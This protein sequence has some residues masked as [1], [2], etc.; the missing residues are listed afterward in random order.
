M[1]RSLLGTLS[2]IV[3]GTGPLA[4]QFVQHLPAGSLAT[5]AESAAESA[6]RNSE[7]APWKL[8][9]LALD[10]RFSVRDLG[11]HENVFAN[12]GETSA[13]NDF[14]GTVG[15]GLA[16]YLNLGSKSLASA[17]VTPEYSWWRDQDE[18][19]R[20][21]TSWGVGWFGFF[22]NLTA[23]ARFTVKD[24]E[25]PLSDEV[26]APVR[27]EEET[28]EIRAELSLSEAFGIVASATSTN[29]RHATG[30]DSFVPGLVAS[31]LDRDSETL[32]TGVILNLR[33]WKLGVG[34]ESSEVDVLV[35][36]E[37]R[38]STGDSPF[39]LV[40]YQSERIELELTALEREVE[41]A[42]P[43]LGREELKAGNARLRLRLTPATS[44]SLYGARSLALAALE[45]DGYVVQDRFGA[46]LTSE[47]ASRFEVTVL[48]ETGESEFREPDPS[49]RRDALSVLGAVLLWKARPE[50]GLRVSIRE[51]TWDSNLDAF[52]RS[53]QYLGIDLVLGTGLFPW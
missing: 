52:D 6:R 40:E 1:R 35:D 29:Y 10:P 3:L 43:A 18:L 37:G 4:A 32:S 2:L 14:R 15:A 33:T 13:V 8:G 12:A 23:T 38:S 47:L 39:A 7:N 9:K 49:D 48:A 36:P 51:V 19:S 30:A 21:N 46:S 44:L 53:Q 27:I 41:F 26:E 50:L 45:A 42:N 24:Q 34:L 28:G 25:Q 5:R 11:Y 31:S 16:A 20:F 17:F 22:N